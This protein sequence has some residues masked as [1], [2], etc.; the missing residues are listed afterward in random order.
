MPLGLEPGHAQHSQSHPS[1]VWSHFLQEAHHV[2][3][4]VRCPSGS[5]Y[6]PSVA[7]TCHFF[8][9]KLTMRAARVLPK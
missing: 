1:R 4:E 8:L 2:Q 5:G 9:F 7:L 6:V 3:T